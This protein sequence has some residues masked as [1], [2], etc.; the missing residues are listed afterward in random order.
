MLISWNWTI[1]V[2]L[3][4]LSDVVDNDVKKSECSKLKSKVAR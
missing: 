1:P 4:K 2:D 3:K